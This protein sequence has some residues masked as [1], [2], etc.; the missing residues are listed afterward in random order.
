MSIFKYKQFYSW[1]KSEELD[2]NAL[3]IA[4][5]EIEKGLFEANLG[6]GLYKKRIARK[7]KGKSGGYR[8]LLAFK[9]GDKAFFL[10]GFSK[11]ERANISKK[12]EVVL[13]KLAGCYLRL[14]E[15]QLKKLIEDGELIEVK[16]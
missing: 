5:N 13:K 15:V 8:T 16:S 6:S 11:N 4:V 12:E 3:V 7:G 2:D 14:T 1:A 10:Y 9:Q